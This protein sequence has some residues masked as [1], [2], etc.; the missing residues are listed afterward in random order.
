MAQNSPMRCPS[1]STPA[2][3]GQRFCAECGAMLSN[4]GNKPT[5]RASGDSYSTVP[6][7]GAQFYGQTTE[8]DVIPPPPP[9]NSFISQPQPSPASVPPAPTPGA[10]DV[11]SYARAPRRSRG[12]LVVSVVLLLVLAAGAAG[13]YFGFIRNHSGASNNN[14]NTSTS[15]QG[16]QTTG[17]TPTPGNT[18]TTSGT[19]GTGSQASVPLNLAFTYATINYTITSVQY[20]QSYPDDTSITAGGVRVAFTESNPTS[21]SVVFA[22]SDVAR[23]IMP[24]G[25][26]VAPASTKNSSPPAPSSSGISNWIDFPVTTQPAD[27]TALKLQMGTAS[28]NQMLIPLKPGA[29]LSQYQPATA[30]PNVTFTYAGIQWTINK[31]VI[32]YSAEGKQA[33]TGNIYVTLSLTAVNNSGQDFIDNAFSYMRLKAGGVVNPPPDDG[34]F[35]DTIAPS[36]TASGDVTFLMPQGNTSYTLEMLAQQG[37]PPI[38]AA[39]QNFQV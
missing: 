10:Y 1:C 39:S 16:T 13:I 22:Y 19:G 6:K 27:L 23:L 32:T 21:V 35:P 2:E 5:E 28:E 15:H 33:T 30:S 7:S 9:P 34:T 4:E 24:D 36:S 26:S 31:A 29:D 11:P 3:A 18:P 14:T 37:N 25:S 17:N 38:Q 20:A 12:C 8:A